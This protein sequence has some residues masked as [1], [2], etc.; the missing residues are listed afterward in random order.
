MGYLVASYAPLATSTPVSAR[1]QQISHDILGISPI[2]EISESAHADDA[3]AS[4]DLENDG[5]S[6]RQFT[7]LGDRQFFNLLIFMCFFHSYSVQKFER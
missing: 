1:R 7:K 2:G 3:S 5:M 6:G 4:G